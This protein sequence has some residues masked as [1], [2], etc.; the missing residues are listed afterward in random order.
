MDN[1]T[2]NYH[3]IVIAAAFTASYK[4]YMQHWD[5]PCDE[6]DE[7]LHISFE[8]GGN[9]SDA[10]K[11][12]EE[13]LKN[14]DYKLLGVKD[15]RW[16]INADEILNG[17]DKRIDW[18]QGIVYPFVEITSGDSGAVVRF[19]ATKEKMAKMLPKKIFLSHKSVDK[20]VVREYFDLLKAIGFDPW[21]DEDAMTAGV[22][23]ERALLDGMK[24]SCASVFF[25]TSNYQDERYLATEIDYAVNERR[26]KGEKHFTIITLVLQDSNGEKGKVPELLKPYVWKEPKSHLEA[27]KEIIKALPIYLSDMKWKKI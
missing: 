17:N 10:L 25:V 14:S 16:W 18:L 22:S 15:G 7:G 13:T 1:N 27:M 2:T 19:I 6:I 4:I 23:L 26:S 21:I 12:L 8:I 5:Y 3:K 11:E 9:E 24:N 20:P